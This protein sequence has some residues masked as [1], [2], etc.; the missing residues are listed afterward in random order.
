MNLAN[1][2]SKDV[3]D[4]LKGLGGSGVEDREIFFVVSEKKSNRQRN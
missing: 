2:G 3:Q 4:Q 1:G